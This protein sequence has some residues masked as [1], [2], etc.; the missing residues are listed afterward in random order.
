MCFLLTDSLQD[1]DACPLR[2]LYHLM[3]CFFTLFGQERVKEIGWSESS[4]HVNISLVNG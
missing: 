1:K 4:Y 2:V 3:N